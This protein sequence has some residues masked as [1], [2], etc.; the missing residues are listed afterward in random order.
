MG[1]G[2]QTAW[3]WEHRSYGFGD[4]PRAAGAVDCVT[5]PFREAGRMLEKSIDIPPAATAPTAPPQND[6][7]F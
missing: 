7:A 1:F 2:D 3:L 6:H 4:H 5:K